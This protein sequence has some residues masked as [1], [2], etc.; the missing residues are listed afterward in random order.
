MVVDGCTRTAVR[1]WANGDGLREGVHASDVRMDEKYLYLFFHLIADV[2][3][4]S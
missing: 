1:G 4:F 3:G 2:L